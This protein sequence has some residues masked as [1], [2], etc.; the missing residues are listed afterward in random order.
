LVTTI[1]W[2]TDSL[3]FFDL[4]FAG[5]AYG[6]YDPKPGFADGKYYGTAVGRCVSD[7]KTDIVPAV[8]TSSTYLL[9]TVFRIG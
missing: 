8:S 5:A 2:P 9:L 4:I 7:I 1:G 3:V 6:N